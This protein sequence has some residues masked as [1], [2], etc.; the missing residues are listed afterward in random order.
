MIEETGTRVTYQSLTNDANAQMIL[1]SDIFVDA[2]GQH[3][4]GNQ[5]WDETGVGDYYI[6]AYA[7]GGDYVF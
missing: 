3:F 6:S 7:P 4:L 2:N 1:E 5:A